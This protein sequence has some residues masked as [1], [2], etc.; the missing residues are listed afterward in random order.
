MAK[1]LFVPTNSR[2]VAQFS[3]VKHEL[4]INS[5]CDVL[6]IALDEKMEPLLKEKG[7][8]Y[9]RIID[10]KT[11]NILNIIKDEEPDIVVTD[12]CGPIPNALIYA[13]NHASIPSLQVDDG[14][15]TDYSALKNI[16][17]WQSFQYIMRQIM[18]G[19]LTGNIR[20]L[21][22]L[23]VTLMAINN[24]FQFLRK[25][26]GEIRRYSYPVPSYIEGLNIAV[27]SQFAKDAYINMGVPSERVFVT[28]QPGFD[29]I[30]TRKFNRE[31]L[32]SE[33]GIPQSKGVAVLATQ[34]LVPWLW[35][36]DDR[37]TFIK[38]IVQAIDNSPDEQLIIKLHPGE[39]IDDYHRVLEE[40]G[41][42]KAIIC[43]NTDLYELLNACN[44]LMTV[45]STVALEA[46]LLNKPVICI[47]LTGH[48]PF[49]SFYTESGAAAG[50][51]REEELVPAIQKALNDSQARD[52]QEQNRKRFINKR[53]YKPDGQA[54]KRVAELVMQLIKEA[55]KGEKAPPWFLHQVMKQ[56]F[57]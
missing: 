18:S 45:H 21:S 56:R 22:C 44:L 37:R 36:E 30:F 15:T 54:S 3:L 5:G 14:I 11:R 9:K 40:I 13:A 51:Y 29:L 34:P 48:N 12:F 39:N 26:V 32:L 17:P 33:L 46:M 4:E 35:S 50:V 19:K 31:R 1:L 7:F 6:A 23:V 25:V 47:D 42:N 8:S 20:P 43:Q 27:M 41:K 49:T 38:T 53:V 16:P 24:P 28:G 52:E 2:E 55:K 10:Y 57:K